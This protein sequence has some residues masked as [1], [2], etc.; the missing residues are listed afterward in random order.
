MKGEALAEKGIETQEIVLGVR[1][2]H[3]QLSHAGDPHAFRCTIRVN[4]MMGSEY[5]IHALTESNQEIIVRTPTMDLTREEREQLEH[6]N[7]IYV[8]FKGKV[9]HFFDKKTQ[10]NLLV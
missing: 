5:H 9:M 10:K 8:T 3:I 4:E 2:E 1:P 6:G 7:E